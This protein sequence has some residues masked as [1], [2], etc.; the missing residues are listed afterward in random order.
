MLR[1]FVFWDKYSLMHKKQ[2]DI[3]GQEQTKGKKLQTK[4]TTKSTTRKASNVKK[5]SYSASAD[6]GPASPQAMSDL[7]NFPHPSFYYWAQH[8]MEWNVVS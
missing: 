7:T 1:K 8:C 2:K 5:P 6:W 4:Q 3:G